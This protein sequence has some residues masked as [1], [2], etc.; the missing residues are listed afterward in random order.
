MS[1]W[2]GN[3]EQVARRH[4]LQVTHEHFQRAVRRFDAESD[5]FVTQDP[6]SHA[7]AE[8]CA[9][10][11]CKEKT[12][13]VAGVTRSPATRRETGEWRIGDSNP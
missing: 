3:S 12:P 8:D 11:R 10:P 4:Y 7:T 6:M 5:A 9:D 13:A 1:S 2:I